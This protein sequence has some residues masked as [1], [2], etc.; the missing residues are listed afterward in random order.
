MG[1]CLIPKDNQMRLS[2]LPN[3]D[4]ALA[5]VRILAG[6]WENLHW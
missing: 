5:L 6:E 3:A 1:V 4:A 2:E